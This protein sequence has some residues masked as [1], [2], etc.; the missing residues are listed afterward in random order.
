M[1]FFYFLAAFILVRRLRKLLQSS[2]LYLKW[3][4]IF[5]GMSW[6][7][8]IL[9]IVIKSFLGDVAG[10]FIGSFLLLGLLVYL[11]KQPDFTAYRSL[12]QAGLPLVVAGLLSS[13]MQAIAPEFYSK[14]DGYF[15]FS[16]V[17]AFI[18]IFARWA[19]SKKQLQELKIVEDRKAELEVLVAERTIA[20]TQQQETLQA[21][22]M[23]LQ[24]MQAQLVQQEKLASLGELTAGI[25]HEIQNPL[26][27]VNNFSE[28]STE[29]LDELQTGPLQSLQESEKKYA[30]EI[31]KDLTS[32]LEKISFHG[33]RA[34][35]IVKG[36][37]QHSRTS[38]GQKEPTDLNALADEYL[39]LSYH[40]L[41]AKDNTFNARLETD[42][43]SNLPKL[44]VVP[45]DI[46]RVLLN[47]FNNAFYAVQQKKAK[48]QDDEY[49]PLVRISTRIL[50]D[51]VE[52]RIR[53]NGCGVSE[54]IRHKI[55]QPF[56]TTK[57]TGQGTGLGL[58]LS[59]DI[60]TKGHNGEMLIESEDGEFAEFI[61]RLPSKA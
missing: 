53:D 52:L 44:E 21:T 46:G 54:N 33:K 2:H 5:N 3:S 55:L 16:V 42:F 20:L 1:L 6:I 35:S 45:Q 60:I 19:N 17:G 34:E 7:I 25:A 36:M 28:V 58:S 9:F 30:C 37:L 59:Y 24:A 48:R 50:G 32:N 27:F 14:W 13:L 4:S 18:W 49:Q 41:R 11:N 22:I 38:T 23:E 47:L 57:P 40:G 26:N 43:D 56:F 8:P 15:D 61:I 10:E 29:L 12:I 39:R 51:I 31:M